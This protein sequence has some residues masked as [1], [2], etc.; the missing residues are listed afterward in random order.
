MKAIDPPTPATFG[1]TQA[2]MLSKSDPKAVIGY[3]TKGKK[4]A[5]HAMLVCLSNGAK[6]DKESLK[7]PY[8]LWGFIY[9]DAPQHEPKFVKATAISAIEFA[10]SGK[11][12]VAVFDSIHELLGAKAPENVTPKKGSNPT[13]YGEFSTHPEVIAT[14]ECHTCP[15]G[16]LC[17]HLTA[18]GEE[19]SDE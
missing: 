16:N 10:V 19:V 6:R 15:V 4:E 2:W 17:Q 9:L 18:F 13:C 12:Q 8:P 7:P 5:R 3:V 1:P 11:A 14:R